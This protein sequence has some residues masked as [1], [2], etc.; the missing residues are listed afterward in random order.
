MFGG[1]LQVGAGLCPGPPLGK[2]T[3][4]K[5]RGGTEPAPCLLK[6]AIGTLPPVIAAAH[7]RRAAIWAVS[8][9]QPVKLPL[10]RRRAIPV[11][12]D[13]DKAPAPGILSDGN[14]SDAPFP[15]RQAISC[16]LH[17]NRWEPM[18]MSR[19]QEN[20]LLPLPDTAIDFPDESHGCRGYRHLAHPKLPYPALKPQYHTAVCAAS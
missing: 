20:L 12:H 2:W 1:K 13:P 3:I 4:P 14:C 8:T 5:K 10:S 18:S 16:L 15:I 9:V 11:P 19:R 17:L 7:I 6:C